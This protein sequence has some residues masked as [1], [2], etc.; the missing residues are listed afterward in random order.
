MSGDLNWTDYLSAV[1]GVAQVV[2]AVIALRYAL[3]ANRI[4]RASHL[5]QR[6]SADLATVAGLAREAHDSF[7]RLMGE[8]PTVPARKTARKTWMTSHELVQ[9]R[10]FD[11]G[12]LEDKIKAVAVA[13]DKVYEVDRCTEEDRLQIDYTERKAAETAYAKAYTDFMTTIS[14]VARA[15]SR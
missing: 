14:G 15:L 10:L 9:K 3:G 4:S 1:S 12:V 5:Q 2:T 11:L 8:F 6:L 13:W 7:D